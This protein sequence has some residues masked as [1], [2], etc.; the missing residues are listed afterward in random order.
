TE[1]LFAIAIVP[2]A[3][4][5]MFGRAQFTPIAVSAPPPLRQLLSDCKSP[6]ALLLAALLFFQFG[7]EWSVAGWLAV[8]LIHRLGISP[9]AALSFLALYWVSLF[10]GRV[11][12]MAI[13]P[14]VPHTRLLTGSAAAA[15]FGCIVLLSTNNQFGATTG[16]LLAGLGFSTIFPLTA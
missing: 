14:R 4:T 7:N 1:I 11:A 5:V 6:R 3:F 10:T 16:V 8:F 2:A 12:A 9:E 15:V 13:L